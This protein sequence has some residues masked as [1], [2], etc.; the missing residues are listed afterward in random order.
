MVTN[1]NMN[2]TKE[3]H[4]DVREQES[5]LPETTTSVTDPIIQK[6]HELS[7]QVTST[8]DAIEL[9]QLFEAIEAGANA[10]KAC[11]LVNL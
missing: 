2:Y 11:R 3:D 8:K 5:T 1:N 10:V 7:Q 6:I 9:K 4:P